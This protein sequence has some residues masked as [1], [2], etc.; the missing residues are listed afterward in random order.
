MTSLPPSEFGGKPNPKTG[1]QPPPHVPTA[2]ERLQLLYRTGD[3]SGLTDPDTNVW[4]GLRTV[5]T[6]REIMT[7]EGH[8]DKGQEWERLV[9]E[10]EAAVEEIPRV[11]G[12]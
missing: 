5:A 10:G 2:S 12:Q 4:A 7:A 11:E 1:I 9:Q 8:M 3:E 6:Q